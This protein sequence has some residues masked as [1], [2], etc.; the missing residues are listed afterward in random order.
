MDLSILTEGPFLGILIFAGLMQSLIPSAVLKWVMSAKFLVRVPYLL[1][2]VV[3]I[4]SFGLMIAIILWLGLFE[5][6][7]RE[8]VPF[9]PSLLLYIA[10]MLIQLVLLTGFVPDE[11]GDLL[12]MWQWFV[13]QLL[14]IVV[15]FVV[16]AVFLLIALLF[17]LAINA[18]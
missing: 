10:G 4:V 18:S 2:L 6:A 13:G 11:N 8:Q 5:A 3:H 12:P 14:V 9:V 7:A 15:Y 1:I 17:M 16:G